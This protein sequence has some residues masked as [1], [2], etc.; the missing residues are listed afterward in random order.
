MLT[1]AFWAVAGFADDVPTPLDFGPP[2]ALTIISG[3]TRHD[4]NVEIADTNVKRARGYMFRDAVGPTQ[5]MLFEFER[6]ELASIYMKNTSVFLDILF[7]RPD[8]RILKIEHSA[9]PY[10]LR[11]MTSEAPVAAVLEIA[12]GQAHALG[13]QPGDRVSHGFFKTN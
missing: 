11:S 4:F 8:G 1:S 3:E 9:K 6:V 7:V 12:G 5:G 10:S 2:E 13:I